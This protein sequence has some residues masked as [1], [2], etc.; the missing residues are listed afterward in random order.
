MFWKSTEHFSSLVK[1]Q[2]FHEN[3]TNSRL[4]PWLL[5]TSRWLLQ[6]VLPDAL[7]CTRSNSIL[8]TVAPPP[9]TPP[10]TRAIVR[11]LQVRSQTEPRASAAQ[12]EAI[13]GWTLSPELASWQMPS[14]GPWSPMGFSYREERASRQVW[15][16]WEWTGG[17]NQQDEVKWQGIYKE[18]MLT[19]AY[20][21]SLIPKQ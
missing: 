6:V 19:S 3:T 21:Q 4:Q 17:E 8:V 12:G 14:Q 5:S 9:P 16:S 13:P 2:L 7:S 15:R 1:F 10:G 20:K 18:M 11:R